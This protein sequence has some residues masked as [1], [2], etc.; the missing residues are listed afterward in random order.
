MVI[1]ARYVPA[2][3]G[4]TAPGRGF[5]RITVGAGAVVENIDLALAHASAITGR[6]VDDLSDPIEGAMVQ[7]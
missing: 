1:K 7:A 3:Y 2:Q 6:I 4:E 5:K